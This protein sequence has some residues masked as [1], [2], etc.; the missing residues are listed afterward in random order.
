MRAAMAVVDLFNERSR[1][2]ATLLRFG[3]PADVSC[4]EAAAARSIELRLQLKDIRARAL[5]TVE[6]AAAVRVGYSSARF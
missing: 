6:N 3:V 1:H 5:G 2:D 4:E